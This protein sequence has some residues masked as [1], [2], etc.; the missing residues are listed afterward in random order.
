MKAWLVPMGAVVVAFSGCMQQRV[1][2]SL[3]EAGVVEGRRYSDEVEA[4]SPFETVE[5]PWSEA[6][7]LMEKRNRSFIA[8]RQRHEKAVED[9]PLV[10]ELTRELTDTVTVSLGDLLNTDSLLESLRAPATRLPKQLASIGKLKDLSHQMEQSAWNDAATSVDAEFAMRKEKVRLHRLLR[11]GVL[12]DRELERARSAPAPPAGSDPKFVAAFQGWRTG[13]HDAREKWLTEV[14]NLFDAEYHDVRF[15]PDD[16][17]LPTYRSTDHPDLGEWQRWCRLS[18]S[19]ELVEALSETHKTSKPAVPGTSMVTD[20]LVHLVKGGEESKTVRDTASVR[21][22]V[23]S[24]IQS[25]RGMKSAQDKAELLERSNDSLAVDSP[26][27]I[28]ARQKIFQ[29]RRDEIQH[30]SVVWM[31]DEACWQ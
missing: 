15:I 2:E 31:L 17:G 25:W 11:M 30:A 3:A 26:A 1:D 9:A 7:E 8:A 21:A 29:L 12:I 4:Q 27:R 24:L 5:I 20:S 16:S 22:E 18:R 23:R 19:K 6:D 13:L 14:R 28:Q 10:G